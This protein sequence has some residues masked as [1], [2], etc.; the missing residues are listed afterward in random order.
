M[1]ESA[2]LG[3]AIA[4]TLYKKELPPL[5]EALLDAQLEVVEKKE[6]PVIIVVAGVEGA[7]KGDTVNTLN[8]WMDPRHIETHAFGPMSEE[9]ALRPPMWRFWQ[10][11]PEKGKI[12]IFFG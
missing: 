5:R 12:G 10:R 9:E 7:G 11:M 8:E 6:F 4:K 3:H 1:F 2:E